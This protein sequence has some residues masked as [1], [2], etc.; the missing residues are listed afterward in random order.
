MANESCLRTDFRVRETH[1]TNNRLQR[2]RLKIAKSKTVDSCELGKAAINNVSLISEIVHDYKRG[3]FKS[4]T[5]PPDFMT[6]SVYL[7]NHSEVQKKIVETFNSQDKELLLALENSCEDDD[8]LDLQNVSILV[9][10]A[11]R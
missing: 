8:S 4:D 6:N 5:S 3:N 10:L 1:V 2:G 9:I 11:I 7:M